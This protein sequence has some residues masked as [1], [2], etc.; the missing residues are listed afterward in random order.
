MGEPSPAEV[1]RMRLDLRGFVQGVGFRPFVYRL[2]CSEGLAG[3]VRNTG[4]GV[5]I[6]IEGGPLPLKRF[7][8]RLETELPPHAA[9][10]DRGFQRIAPQADERFAVLPSEATAGAALLMPDRAICAD[11][12]RDIVDPS[13]RHFSYGF[14]SCMHCGP[15]F[16]IQ[17]GMP[18]D[19]ARTAMRRF[20]LCAACRADYEDPASRRFHAEQISCP[21]C[22]PRLA[23]WDAK[24]NAIAR[25][26]D[27]L[28]DAATALRDGKILAL[29]GLGGFQLIVD[30]R[31]DD[32]VLRLRMRKQRPRKPF[33]LMVSSLDEADC[34]ADISAAERAL[35]ASSEAPIVLV[36]ARPN[37]LAA[38]VA[39][40]NPWLG[41]M[42]ASTPLHHLL[43]AECGGPI[44]A[45]SGNRSSEPIV[46]DE[47][48]ALTRLSGIAD[49]FLVHD[50]PIVHALDDSV[51][52]IIAGEVTLLRRARGYAPAPIA[53]SLVEAPLLAL[54]GQHK[55][56]VAFGRAG[57]IFVSAH[58][59]DLDMAAA[60]EASDREAQRFILQGDAPTS[61]ICDAH[62]DYYTSQAAPRFGVPVVC[63]PHH[64]GHVLSCM[65]DNEIEG[66]VLGVAF[67]G[68]GY[69][70]DGTIWGGEF[71]AVTET[72]HRRVA[73]LLPFPLPGGEAAVREP[74]R[75]ALGALSVM[76]GVQSRTLLAA[77]SEAE[78]RTL[79]KMLARGLNA[80]A[81]SSAGRLFDAAAS[82]LGL[83]QVATFEGEAAMAVEAAAMRARQSQSLAPLPLVEDNEKLVLDWRPML[84]S[85]I[86]ARVDGCAVEALAAGLHEALASAIVAVAE[87]IGEPRV[88]LS[89]GC[90]QNAILTQCAVAR[91]RAAGFMPYW[92]RRI[93]PNDGGLAVGQIAYAARQRKERGRCVLPCP[94]KS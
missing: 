79:T 67:D 77:F 28:R 58:I 91:L 24:G 7:L 88:L 78:R 80:P 33:A 30:A 42:L 49:L 44:V 90:F 76:C 29:K 82:L 70:G 45:T 26:E 20:P 55:N 39:P 74:R 72:A 38:S 69:G 10:H 16:S 31:N 21:A 37:D 9:I 89:G 3:F 14:T 68:T 2:A 52:R 18:Y 32:A 19:R 23:L 83:M 73:H 34:F 61:V 35:L 57:K 64:L 85:L 25:P 87:R 54:G 65:A 12:L 41:I 63:V 36:P 22:G 27:A 5:A 60:R 15:R 59:G 86:A 94:A 6:E 81:T 46:I 56:T 40:A 47:D 50:R 84:A 53:C 17:E 62:P 4:D 8:K 48:E 71:L 11:C 92:H 66:S 1:Q 75:A 51:A 43:L 93:P 13:N